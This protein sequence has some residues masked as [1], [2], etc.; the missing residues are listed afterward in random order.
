VSDCELE[1]QTFRIDNW[2]SA[3]I[4][5]VRLSIE[6]AGSIPDE[7]IFLDLPNP[8]G[9]IR[10]CGDCHLVSVTDLYGRILDFLDRSRYF[11]IQ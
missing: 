4:E 10:P 1:D 5:M 3:V 2:I 8:S 11:S 6:F 9:C 7:V